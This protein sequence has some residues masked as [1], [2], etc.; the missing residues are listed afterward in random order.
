MSTTRVKQLRGLKEKADRGL[1]YLINEAYQILGNPIILYDADWKI[2]AYSENVIC[3]DIFWNNHV[4]EKTVEKNIKNFINEGF[5]DAMIRPNKVVLLKSDKVKYERLF[6]K[7]FDND[8]NILGGV[9]VVAS[10]KPF[11]DDDFRTTEIICGVLSKEILKIPYYQTYAQEKMEKCINMLISKE[12]EG[13]ENRLY[14]SSYVEMV[15]TGLKNYLYVAVAILPNAPTRAELE[16]Y[17]ELFKQIRPAFKY[18]I[19]FNYVV[20]I[21]SDDEELLCPK[22]C[23]NRLNGVLKRDNIKI[24]ISRR[25]EN[26]FE[27]SKYYGEAVCALN[28][29]LKDNGNQYI[30][31]YDK[32]TL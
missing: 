14:A 10:N 13:T 3:D 25:F 21:M 16:Y 20:I 28:Q 12:I 27:L 23:F 32:N 15:Y 4:N 22:I 24:G 17:K 19:Y 29:G 5:I 26:L 7:V 31:V 9:S 6:G 30:F 2:L 1:K 8:S 18:S 11:E